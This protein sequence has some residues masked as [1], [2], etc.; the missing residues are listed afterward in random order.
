MPTYRNLLPGDPAPWFRQRSSVNPNYAFDSAAGRYLVLCFF[1][2]AVNER[3]RAALEGAFARR[4]LFDDNTA[5]FF[6]V[7]IDPAD[8][9]HRRVTTTLPVSLYY[10]DGDD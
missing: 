4:A 9:A 5:A 10:C 8:V 1:L 6:G 3:A 7:S 2:S